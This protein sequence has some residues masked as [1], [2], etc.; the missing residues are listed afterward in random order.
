MQLQYHLNYAILKPVS[1][2][3]VVGGCQELCTMLED[4]VHVN[5]SLVGVVCN[6]LCDYVGID[7]GVYQDH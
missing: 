1:D 3:G 4:A 2:V 7:Q 6:L 5:S